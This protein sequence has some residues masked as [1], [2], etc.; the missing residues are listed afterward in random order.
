MRVLFVAP[1]YEPAWIYGGMVRATFMWARALASTGIQVTV[2]TTTANGACELD[3][4]CGQPL[5]RDG[6]RVIYYP[7]WRWTG[8]RFV[9]PALLQ[10]C[11][12]HL[13]NYD[14][15]H[16][17]GLWTFPSWVAGLVAQRAGKP[18]L[19][20]A[21]GTLIPWAMQ[22]HGRIKSVFFRFLEKPRL[23]HACTVI[24]TSELEKRHYLELGFPDRVEIVPNVVD[25]A[26]VCPRPDHFRAHYGLQ[27]TFVFLFAGR[28]VENKGVNFDT[29]CI[30]RNCR[31]ASKYA[32]GDCWPVGRRFQ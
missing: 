11:I 7:R 8:S 9:S 24:C 14:V 32:L 20:S 31:R 22:H 19:V 28:L 12:Q 27:D 26:N 15:V 30:C 3:L 21:H 2:W 6:V 13:R 18:Y 1:F 23:A 10:A 17:T 5:I 4:P 16:A 29:G 25:T